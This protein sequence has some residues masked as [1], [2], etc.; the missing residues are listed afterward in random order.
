MTTFLKPLTALIF[1]FNPFSWLR[2][3]INKPHL[4]Y[5]YKSMKKRKVQENLD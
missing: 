2:S 4:R 1:K 5:H 3:K